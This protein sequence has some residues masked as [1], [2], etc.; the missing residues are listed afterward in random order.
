MKDNR[1]NL[2]ISDRVHRRIK[3]YSLIKRKTM[4]EVI[5]DLIEKYCDPKSARIEMQQED[6]LLEES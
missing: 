1:I 5:T 4:T 2:R 3:M 6:Q